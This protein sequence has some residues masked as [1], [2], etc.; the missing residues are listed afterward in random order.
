MVCIIFCAGHLGTSF[1]NE[2]VIS[3]CFGTFSKD[4][5]LDP[6]EE[7]AGWCVRLHTH[8]VSDMPPIVKST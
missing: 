7:G 3:S 4:C 2:N 1:G 5:A 6:S 8:F